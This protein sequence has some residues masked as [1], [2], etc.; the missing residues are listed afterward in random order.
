MCVIAGYVG[1]RRAAPVL[2][3]MI[4]RQEGLAGGFYTGLATVEAGRLYWR[5]VVGDLAELRKCPDAEQLPGSVGVA[6]SRSNSGGD[7]EWAHPFISCEDMVAYIA[8]GS[9]GVSTYALVT[10]RS[11]HPGT[12]QT[13]LVDGSVRSVQETIDPGV[14]RALATR[15]GGEVVP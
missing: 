6:H 1:T 8:N 15:A 5:K 10:S 13:A 9:A 7:V 12:V 14:W 11:Y 4:E 3:E 2:L